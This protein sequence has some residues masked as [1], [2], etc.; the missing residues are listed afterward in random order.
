VIFTD[1]TKSGLVGRIV[2]N[3]PNEELVVEY[4][5]EYKD[6]V[7]DYD[8]ESAKQIK[9]GKEAYKLSEKD[10]KTQLDVTGDMHPDFYDMM[11]EAWEKAIK[12]IKELAEKN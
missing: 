9:G 6:G 2:V 7:E 3:K 4:E 5:G 8:S 12:K 11:S 1:P 10:G